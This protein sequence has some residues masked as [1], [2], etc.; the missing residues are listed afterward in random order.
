MKKFISKICTA[1]MLSLCAASFTGCGSTTINLNDYV[2]VAFEGYE[3]VGTA[4]STL[5]INKIIADHPEA[6]NLK[7]ESG[8]VGKAAVELV[9]SS[10]ISGKLDKN[11]QLKNGETIN[12][13][14]GMTSLQSVEE[15]YPV[16]FDYKDIPYTIAGLKEAEEFDPFENIKVT[17]GGTAPNGTAKVDD[18]GKA[19]QN[20]KYTATPAKGLKNG[21]T[22]KVT[23]DANNGKLDEYCGSQG[24]IAKTKEKEY[25]V[26]G[27]NA[28]AAK[29]DEIPK[30]TMDKML[31]QSEDNL[32]ARATSWAEGNTIKEIKH[33]GCYFLTE[34]EGFNARNKNQIYLVFKVTA[35]LKGVTADNLDKETEGEDSYYTYVAFNN[36]M[37]LADGTVSVDLSNNSMPSK[38]TRSKYG[39]KSWGEFSGYYFYGY[40]E[41][42]SMFSDCVT[43]QSANCDYENTVKE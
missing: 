25:K 23:V 29:L 4:K 39:R 40:G 28:Y 15:K 18:S 42:D 36:I 41:L 30:E 1:A 38:E 12:W 27:L 31:K 19:L 10:A 17:F 24:K 33:I 20:L 16:K 14:W 37:I 34:K 6:F 9:L 7:A 32:R 11:S 2:T 22:V 35:N 13:K 43:S 3:T 5:D 26:E 21:D 8:D